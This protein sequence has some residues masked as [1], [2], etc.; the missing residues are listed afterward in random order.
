M[1]GSPHIYAEAAAR[2]WVDAWT[3]A[4]P[5]KDPEPVASLY[6]DDAIFYSQPFREPLRG[7]VGVR[8]YM[9]WAFSEQEGVDFAF[10]EPIVAADR[11]AVEWWA[12]ITPPDGSEETVV[13][14]SVLRFAP[15]GHVVE[16]TAHWASEP[17]RREPPAWVGG[18][19]S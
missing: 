8:E 6:A 15:D 14:V 4:W 1:A 10:G 11:A 19:R 7:P 13:G 3:R 16:D 17:G 12:V 2:A 5:A 9:E 18:A